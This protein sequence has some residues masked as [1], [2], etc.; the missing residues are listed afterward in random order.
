MFAGTVF[1]LAM[2]T[3]PGRKQEIVH[4]Y[5]YNLLSV[6]LSKKCFD[7][8]LMVSL[9]ICTVYVK[10]KGLDQQTTQVIIPILLGLPAQ[11]GVAAS[12]V[13]GPKELVVPRW[14]TQLPACLLSTDTLQA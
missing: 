12:I 8:P 2:T 6:Y 14:H 7:V 13:A 3:D 11:P 9:Q 5:H 1:G 10:R 4:E